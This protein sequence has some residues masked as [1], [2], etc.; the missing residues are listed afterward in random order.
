MVKPFTRKDLAN[1]AVQIISKG[2]WG[3]AD[4]YQFAWD[5]AIW[6]VKDFLPCAPVIR[7][8][9]GRLMTQRE[10]QA[11][12]ILKG[13]DGIPAAPFLLDRFAV[14]YRF[15]PGATLKD[16]PSARIGNDFF[17]ELEELVR[18]MHQRN[19]VHL[20]IRNQRNILVTEDN[21]PALLDFQ[22]SLNLENTPRL[23][24]KIMKDIDISGVYKNWDKKKPDS[25]DNARRAH[26]ESLNKKRFL[27]FFKGYPLG[28]QSGRR[29]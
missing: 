17:Y 2:R 24:H 4:L 12:S 9:W 26:L 7:K 13:I 14:C 25:L 21:K 8:T 1:G 15:M 3:N 23:L 10:F 29:S 22:S 6:V 11:L 20:D 19:M 28:T 18:M 16:T 27:W 5:G